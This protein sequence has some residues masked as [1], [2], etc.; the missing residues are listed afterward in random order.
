MINLSTVKF[1]DRQRGAGMVFAAMFIPVMAIAIILLSNLSQLVFEKIKLQQTVDQAAL[2]AAAVQSIGLNELADLNF[3]ALR[4]YYKADL[5]LQ[6]PTFWHD[7]S[8]PLAAIKYHEEIF[9]W[10]NKYREEA[11]INYAQLAHRYAENVIQRNLQGMDVSYEKVPGAS[12]D[13]LTNYRERPEM[14]IRYQYYT[15]YCEITTFFG[16]YPCTY[17]F[18]MLWSNPEDPTDIATAG[19]RIGWRN[20]YNGYLTGL[21]QGVY[22][23]TVRW[24]KDTSSTTYAAY[25]ITQKE[26]RFAVGGNFLQ[27]VF[28]EISVYAAA[29]PTGGIMYDMRPTYVPRLEHLQELKPTPSIPNLSQVDH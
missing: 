2:S 3:S 28:P 6:P 26:K 7:A 10:I 29:K 15:R 18:P 1:A 12:N 23:P 19:S 13:Q 14:P 4:E 22:N 8:Q 24:E 5:A 17:L 27:Q 21:K 16:S 25:K 9:A 20:S 11:N